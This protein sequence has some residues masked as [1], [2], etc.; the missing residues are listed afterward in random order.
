MGATEAVA[1][2]LVRTS[3]DQLPPEAVEAARRAVLDT[4]G[5]ALAGSGQEAGRLVEALAA[6]GG[7]AGQA[8]VWGRPL[9]LPAPE[10]ALV[11]G[12]FAHALDFDDVNDS[13]RGH[14]S[15]PLLPAVLTL[16]EK[17]AASGHR[18]IEA[19]VLGLEVECKLGRA[20]GRSHYS[21][22]WHATAVLGTLGAAAAC[23][24]LLRLDEI[25]TRM[26]L[27]LATSMAS[28]GR[29]NFG[30]M[31]KPFHAGQAARSGLLAALLTH[32]GYTAAVDILD[33][34]APLG[35][36]AL[37]APE[38]DW[39]P[40]EA[41]ASLGDPWDIL[42]PGVSVKKYPCCFAT[43]RALDAVLDLRARHGLRPEAVERVEVV[44]PRGAALPLIY[45]RPRTGPEGKFS[46]EYCLTA[47]LLDGRVRL[48]TF[49]D[50]AVQ[51]PEAQE[52]LPR[53]CLREGPGEA[54]AVVDGYAEVA[55]ITR[56]GSRYEGRV[57]HPR[58]SP[59]VP[60]SW[61]ELVAKFR[62]CASLALPAEAA[63]RVVALV[64]RLQELRDLRELAET[65]SAV[66]EAVRSP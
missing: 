20:L 23:S 12:V 44:M 17:L 50:G 57:D 63:E 7:G 4:L 10:A 22:G 34:D 62:D 21:R 2:F 56:D 46:L 3:Y 15:A 60:L 61:E 51:R 13:M 54:R 14:P 28:G 39:S 19:F 66:G 5:V 41:V 16:A 37:F 64:G 8:A 38:G 31:T 27:G 1:R 45:S 24:R 26:A 65:L 36:G 9:R 32:R 35:F 58:G 18:A 42:S 59:Q 53:V 25:S 47:A 48:S 52:M 6:E 33:A 40:D 55:L 43:H 11:N 49:D 29:A 30:T